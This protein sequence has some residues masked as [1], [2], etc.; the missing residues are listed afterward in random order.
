[1]MINEQNQNMSGD[2]TLFPPNEEK[3]G[4]LYIFISIIGVLLLAVLIYFVFTYED[5][6][7]T[8]KLGDTEEVGVVEKNYFEDLILE[9][10]AVYV[11][12]IASGEVLFEKNAETQLP[13]ASLNKVMVALAAS[14]VVS[15]DTKVTITTSDL[16]EE[17]DTGLL[18]D[19][20]WNF[21][22][23]IDF[24]LV[25]SSNDAIKAI[26]SVAG[27]ALA[28][29]GES[30]D[31][32]FVKRMNDTARNV[33]LTQTYFLNGSGLDLTKVISGGYGSAHDTTLLFEYILKNKPEILEATSFDKITISSD[34][35][36]HIASNT[37]KAINSIPNIIASKTGYTDLSGGNLVI[38]FDAGI[39]RPVAITVLGSTYDGRFSDMEKLVRAVL[40]Y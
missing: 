25:V 23:L 24:A 11:L 10:K 29:D 32:L 15:D 1:M 3:N 36:A 35:K 33:G 18:R 31:D 34:N 38:V 6:I 17:G 40:K 8:D 16:R 21:R 22:R 26:A 14:N 37:N 27:R 20:K 12:D 2:N 19:E 9:A 5:G 4:T 7:I 39:M 13:L 28:V 30:P